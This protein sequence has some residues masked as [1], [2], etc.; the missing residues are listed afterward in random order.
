MAKG[1]FVGLCGLDVV[2]YDV[3]PLPQED[4]K[5]KINDV[6]ACIGGP[7]ANAA[8][9]FSMLG[10]QSTV[11]TYIGNSAVGKIIKEQMRDYGIEVI[12][13]CTDNDVKCISGIYVNKSNFT[14]TIFSGRNNIYGLKSFSVI[15]ELVSAA[16]FVLYDGH[17]SNIDQELL[18]S[19]KKYKRDLV[20]DV[21]GWKD[22]FDYILR[23][24][25]ILICSEVFNK[26][27]RNGIEL[28]KEY[29]YEKA[30]ITRGAKSV[31]CKSSEWD[32]VKEL[33][34]LKVDAI[35]T[36]GAGDVFHGAYCHFAYN[37]QLPF[38]DCVKGAINVAGIS[39][40]VCGVV[41][42]VKEYIE[43]N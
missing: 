4:V 21:G 41:N 19:V 35:D 26:D 42:G 7:A 17:F 38:L 23:Y 33:P 13:L 43:R 14:R 32:L 8:I 2:F 3:K 5:V 11:L 29:G 37:K 31:L 6:R 10:G 27:G 40:T 18:S 25:P 12:D 28:M 22:T 9:T 1:L 16:D 36:L 20:I 34:T 24:N 39:T 30:V 15:E